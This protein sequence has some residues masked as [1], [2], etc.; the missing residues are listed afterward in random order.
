MFRINGNLDLLFFFHI[1]Y[2]DINYKYKDQNEQ[3][4]SAE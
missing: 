1:S 3:N 4:K 2:F